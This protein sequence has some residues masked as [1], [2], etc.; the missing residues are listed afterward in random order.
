[1]GFHI[2]ITPADL[3]WAKDAV[4]KAKLL[5]PYFCSEGI[6]TGFPEQGRHPFR[7][8]DLE[9][10]VLSRLWLEHYDHAAHI[11][12]RSSSY[13]CKHHAEN[14]AGRYIS[15]A[16]L[17]AAAAG[18]GITQK[19]CQPYRGPNTYLAIKYSSWPKGLRYS[20]S[21]PG[22]ESVEVQS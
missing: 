12:R 18:L 7:D 2:I 13:R 8:S 6:N 21:K 3:A 10:V 1:M 4:R 22:I 16:A 14:W 17:I 15:N 19:S 20:T 11:N 9:E 5:F